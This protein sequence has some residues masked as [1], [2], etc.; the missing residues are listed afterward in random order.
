MLQGT[1]RVSS[2]NLR[3]SL[4]TGR[5]A[6]RL[7]RNS[8]VEILGQ[9]TWYRVR[10]RDGKEGFVLGDFID[11]D[12]H[13]TVADSEAPALEGTGPSAECVITPFHH[14]RFVGKPLRA[15][16]D[17][18]PFLERLAGFATSCDV[19][20]HV[21]SSARDPHKNVHG[22]IV[23]PAKRS[24]HMVGHA[25]D[26]NLQ[27]AS[28]FFNSKALKK[29]KVASLPSEIRR[30]IQMVRRDDD[31]RWGGDFSKEDPVH[32]DDGLNLHHPEIWDS[33][34]ESRA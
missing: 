6:K 23:K 5:V 27:S 31:L 32:I 15:D 10:T 25:I 22:A 7:R 33:K 1:V 20:V 28:G 9:Q 14:E 19:R 26:M 18:V 17:F 21:T 29:A 4:T 11:A 8:R 2:L 13:A 34:L 30:F 16:R 24:N 3:R 12:F